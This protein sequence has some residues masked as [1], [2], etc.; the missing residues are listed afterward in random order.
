MKTYHRTSREKA[1]AVLT[2][3]FE[4]R[5]RLHEMPT[6]RGKALLEI[7]LPDEALEPYGHKQ[8]GWHVP[9]EVLNSLARFRFKA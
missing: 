3:G 6:G 1:Q 9:A 4:G 8:G 7:D 2:R 5:V